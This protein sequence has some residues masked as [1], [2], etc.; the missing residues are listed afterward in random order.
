MWKGQGH[1][2]SVF[3]QNVK[4]IHGSIAFPL[5]RINNNFIRHFKLTFSVL[6]YKNLSFYNT[7]LYMIIIGKPRICQ[8]LNIAK[9][10]TIYSL[11]NLL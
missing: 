9:L 2:K 10:F 4:Q 3:T 6:Y 7:Q 1:F 11:D 5:P 8:A